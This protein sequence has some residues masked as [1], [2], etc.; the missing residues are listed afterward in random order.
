MMARIECGTLIRKLGW[1]GLE[2]AHDLLAHD[3]ERLHR[4]LVA[5]NQDHRPFAQLP[6]EELLLS[7]APGT[8]QQ[9]HVHRMNAVST[10]PNN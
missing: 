8:L 1:T 2:M 7:F 5:R 6:W 4:I 3:G 9:P 10:A